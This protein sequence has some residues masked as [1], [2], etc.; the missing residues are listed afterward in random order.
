[1]LLDSPHVFETAHISPS[2]FHCSAQL[3]KNMLYKYFY[4][5]YN[6][7]KRSS[8]SYKLFNSF[9]NFIFY[10][11]FGR[12]LCVCKKLSI[13]MVN[14]IRTRPHIQRKTDLGKIIP[15]IRFRDRKNLYDHRKHTRTLKKTRLAFSDGGLGHPFVY[16]VWCIVLLR[17]YDMLYGRINGAKQS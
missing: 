16:I 10:I 7:R 15:Q 17:G 9:N 14:C 8:Q 4:S 13:M 6:I 5:L 12:E 3:Y 2:I 1:M 11:I